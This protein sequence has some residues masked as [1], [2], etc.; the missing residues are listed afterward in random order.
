MTVGLCEP[1]SPGDE[2]VE[3]AGELVCADRPALSFDRRSAYTERAARA[4][5]GRE[6]AKTDET[7]SLD[8]L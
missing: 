8:E 6:Q 3:R 7:I 1:L 2:T 5:L 4:E